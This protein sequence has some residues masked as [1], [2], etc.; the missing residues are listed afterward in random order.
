MSQNSSIPDKKN[1]MNMSSKENTTKTRHYFFLNP[2]DD[3]A[4][5]KCPKCD[6][7]TK[8]RKYPLVIH[9]EPEQ[10][11]ALNKKCK[12][13]LKCDLI[14]VKKSEIETYM[15]AQFEKVNPSIIG[16]EYLV[17]GTLDRNDWKKYHNTP[18]PPNKAI[19]QMYVF[20]DVLKFEIAR[21]GWYRDS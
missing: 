16:N 17:F 4:F 9:I 19:E 6:S 7:K 2:Y 3:C 10:M 12:Y 1:V 11:F 21:S 15:S 5:T 8:L 13:C 20:K 14:I 18:T